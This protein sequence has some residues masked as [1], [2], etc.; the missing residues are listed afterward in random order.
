VCHAIYLYV[1]FYYKCALFCFMDNMS[2]M[3]PAIRN[4]TVSSFMPFRPR[5][6]YQIIFCMPNSYEVIL[7]HYLDYMLVVRL[8]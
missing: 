2:K 5:T 8:L 6:E 3:Y 1:L 4:K 7:I